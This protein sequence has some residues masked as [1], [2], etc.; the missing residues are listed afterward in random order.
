[1]VRMHFRKDVELWQEAALDGDEGAMGFTFEWYSHEIYPLALAQF[2]WNAR[3]GDVDDLLDAGFRHLYGNSWGPVV[4]RA[5]LSFP[6]VH[7]TQLSDEVMKHPFLPYKFTGEHGIRQLE[8]RRERARQSLAEIEGAIIA[9]R[10][11]PARVQSLRN[12]HTALAR[13]VEI[14]RAGIDYQW[15]RLLAES[16]DPDTARIRAL[17]GSA[18]AHAHEDYRLI[19]EHYFD[20][21]PR[22]STGIALCEYTVVQFIAVLERWLA[23]L[24]GQQAGE[25][26]PGGGAGAEAV[27]WEWYLREGSGP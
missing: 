23:Q 12:L 17:V 27:P 3:H 15:A 13:T 25:P 1:V 10:G 21:A 9:F 2:A 4:G 5:T 6:F 26:V 16:K 20:S 18:L 7:E 19:K 14:C 24:Q 8:E 22:E 11:E